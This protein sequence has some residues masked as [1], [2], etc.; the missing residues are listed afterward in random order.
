MSQLPEKEEDIVTFLYQVILKRDPD[1]SG[2]AT[3]AEKLRKKE[4]TVPDL[5]R[6]LYLSDENKKKREIFRQAAQLSLYDFLLTI[7]DTPVYYQLNSLAAMA[8]RSK[9]L[10][11]DTLFAYQFK[12][13]S[14]VVT[15]RF[16]NQKDITVY[17]TNELMKTLLKDN[18][19]PVIDIFTEEK[20]FE[21]CY[22]IHPSMFDGVGIIARRLD[23]ICN[24]IYANEMINYLSLRSKKFQSFP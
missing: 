8:L 7:K 20:K 4:L 18:G 24:T 10:H 12:P 1:P 5:V 22:F 19:I 15:N 16:V 2:L 11:D 3:Y 23:E 14:L 17:T 21:T 9:D 13:G 6:I